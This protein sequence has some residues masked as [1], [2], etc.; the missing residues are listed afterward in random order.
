MDLQAKWIRPPQDFGEVCPVFFKCFSLSEKPE[1][2]V[3]S[4]TALGVYE[5]FLNGSR[6][7][8]FILAP[9]WTAYEKR[10]Q[11]QDY[12]VTDLVSSKNELSVTVGK[13]WYR[14]RIAWPSP[15]E[16]NRRAKIPAGLIAA[17]TLTFSD[18]SQKRLSTDESWM[19]GESCVRASEIYDGEMFDARTNPSGAL[20]PAVVFDGPTHTLIPQQGPFVTEQ[21]RIAPLS[22]F[23]TPAGER[24]VDFG[25]E[26]TGYPEISL[27][28]SAGETL[29]LSF[30]EV[31]D[32][33][34]NFYTENYRSAKAKYTYLCTD[35]FQTCRPRLTFYGFRY[36]RLDQ[37]PGGTDS[38]CPEQFCAVAIHSRMT[39][40]GYLSCSNPLLNRFFENVVWGQKGNFVDVPT[41]CPQRDERL[42]WTGDAQVFIR[43]ACY[44]FDAKDF[45]TKWL[46]D[47]SAD[48]FEN[49]KVGYV[50]PCVTDV[51][52]S[53][54]A[55]GDAAVICP[56]ELYLAY[57]DPQIL[58]NQF[59]SM[60]KWVDYITLKTTTK[61]L[62]TDGEHY[63]DW[64]GLDAPAGSY[65]GSTREDFIASAFYAHS[66]DLLIRAGKRI[67][68]DVSFY[69]KLY[70]DI[71]EA[72][73]SAYPVYT[74]Q[75]ECVLAAHFHLASNCQAAADQLAKMV[76]DCGIQLQTGFVGTPYLLHVLSDYGYADLAWSLLLRKEYP[77]WLYPVTKGATTV[78]E[79]WDGIMED[80]SFWSKD[81]NSFNHYA[82]GAVLDWVYG[83]AAGISSLPEHP[84]YEKISVAPL[85][86][87]RLDWLS[88]SFQSRFGLIRSE[89]KKQDGMWRYEVETPVDAVITIGGQT[90][91]VGKGTWIYFSKIR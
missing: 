10:L 87:P 89:W 70:A 61:N 38:A 58:K 20:T 84:G 32:Q 69:E 47:L 6:I 27:Q 14:G 52:E 16:T 21:E 42:G 66:T 28:A 43:T 1:K 23:T 85:P 12:D 13:G 79:H 36:L 26:V 7:G 17:L 83:K 8:D 71:A 25:Q 74:T 78:W 76:T 9:G 88:C 80:G 40:T 37:F 48:Q 39:R 50:I 24:V 15:E 33:N 11:V 65:K 90:H 77:S 86:D 57:G 51:P 81:M 62:W 49:G 4:I 72:F 59:E 67:G 34:G 60:K 30:A 2:A 41:D 19:T 91:A 54:A 45:Y 3:L 75:T 5:A 82:Y 73:R 63:G 44:H 35:G 55:W 22:I 18:G 64:L 46:A 31:L 53:S 29:Q 68:A 56:W